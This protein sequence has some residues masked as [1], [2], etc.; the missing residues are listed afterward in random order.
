MKS[1]EFITEGL[2]HPIIV[3]DVQPEYAYYGNN[4]GICRDIIHFV[5]KQTGPVL[6]FINAEE[7]GVSADTKE[8]I[9]EYWENVDTPDWDDLE[10]NYDEDG[11]YENSTEPNVNWN[12]FTIVDKGFGYLRSWMDHGISPAAIIRVI[13]AMYQ[14]K[15]TDSRQFEDLEIDLPALVGQEWDVWMW[16]D[17]ISVEWLSVAQL[18][19]FSGA[20]LVGGGREECLREVEIMMNAFNIPYKRVDSL[21]YG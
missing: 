21:V 6:M 3:V 18:K 1:T 7:T 16:D 12:R 15:I 11:N 8:F 2:A 17:P 4:E 5:T 20:Y 14:A 13:R 9:K 10:D 19:K